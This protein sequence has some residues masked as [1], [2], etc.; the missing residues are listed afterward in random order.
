MITNQSYH[1]S[2]VMKTYNG[3]MHMKSQAPGWIKFILLI[4]GIAMA[5]PSA[6]HKTIKY[7]SCAPF[8]PS[9]NLLIKENFVGWRVVKLSDLSLDDQVQWKRA[10][11]SA[12]P[13]YVN[14]DFNGNGEE[15]Y[16]VTLIKVRPNDR[17]IYQTLVVIS[18]LKKPA[19]I[20]LSPPQ[21]VARVSVV[22]KLPKG[23][24]SDA[25]SGDSV[26]IQHPGIAYEAIEAGSLLFYWDGTRFSSLVISD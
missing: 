25:E 5:W 10:N 24:Y 1:M 22:K 23:R 20:T 13:G 11:D 2:S 7:R 17:Q 3:G 16:A 26:D 15:V 18:I 4:T 21:A 12:C 19:L 6:A 8:P 14:A 9:V